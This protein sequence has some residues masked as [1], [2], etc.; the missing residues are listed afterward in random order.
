MNLR[1]VRLR[2]EFMI[3]A[4]IKL[5]PSSSPPPGPPS[6]LTLLGTH[7][8]ILTLW[9]SFV[10]PDLGGIR[11]Q[12]SHLFL[13]RCFSALLPSRG[14]LSFLLLHQAS[15]RTLS[16]KFH[17]PSLSAL[18]PSTPCTPREATQSELWMYFQVG[19]EIKCLRFRSTAF[20]GAQKWFYWSS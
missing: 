3:V 5:H 16:R 6:A 19:Y 15:T 20:N 9:P 8:L 7:M 2:P 14:D 11:V 4:A 1:W 13:F 18:F 10:G 12:S 17:G